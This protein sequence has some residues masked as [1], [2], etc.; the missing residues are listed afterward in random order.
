MTEQH[1][2][3]QDM[4]MLTRWHYEHCAEYRGIINAYGGLERFNALE[5]VPAIAVRLFKQFRLKS[6][7]DDAVFKV[8]SSS[9]TSSQITSKIYLDQQTASN[10]SKAL[11][12]ILQTYIGKKRVPMM[13]VDHA[14]LLKNRTAF[15]AR[16]AGVQGIS[17]FGRKHTYLL[18]EKMNLDLDKF[19]VFCEQYGQEE[20][21]IFGFTFMVWLNLL[22]QL[23]KEN[24]T[25]SLP[26]A[27]LIHSG[28]W[29]KMQES[30]VDNLEFKKIVEARLG[31]RQVHNF[32]GMVEQT[33]SI[34]MEC[35]AGV[36]HTSAYGDVII[37]D[38]QN[39]RECAVGETGVIQVLSSL[40]KSYPGHSLLTEDLGVLRG[41][42]DC[43]CGRAGKYFHVLGRVPMAEQRGCSDTVTEQLTSSEMTRNASHA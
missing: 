6:I 42:D 15:S 28:G 30:S 39:W 1:A 22:A 21:I 36:L 18:D 8:L 40:P 38:V 14:G 33:G 37:R 16:V 20:L 5:D 10:Q 19:L 24:I 3:L 25:V 11:V 2:F 27:I 23:E 4:Q 34:F 41:R 26:K 13:L 43:A 32:Y 12:R 17:M 7:P 35:E 29:K 31:I 9:G